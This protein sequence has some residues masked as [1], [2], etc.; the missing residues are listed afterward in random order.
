[1]APGKAVR[2]QPLTSNPRPTRLKAI[3]TAPLAKLDGRVDAHRLHHRHRG[4]PRR[5]SRPAMG[6]RRARLSQRRRRRSASRRGGARGHDSAGHVPR[7]WWRTRALKQTGMARHSEALA[8]QSHA[9]PMFSG[10]RPTQLCPPGADWSDLVPGHGDR[11]QAKEHSSRRVSLL[12]RL[13][14]S[15]ARFIA[16][17]A[18]ATRHPQTCSVSV[19]LLTRSV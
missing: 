4:A 11:H 17:R 1:M 5:G 10:V 6:H 19:S 3:N 9:S 2:L 7:H 16:S 14:G 18:R 8:R 13:I 15:H 12:P